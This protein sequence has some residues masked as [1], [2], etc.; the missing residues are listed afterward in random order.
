MDLNS[1]AG[2]LLAIALLLRVFV[3]MK[4]D[5]H[6]KQVLMTSVSFPQR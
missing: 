6:E 3:E 4:K 5:N 2:S 1:C